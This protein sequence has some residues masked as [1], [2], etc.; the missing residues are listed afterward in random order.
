MTTENAETAE[1]P[2]GWMPGV[3]ESKWYP[4]WESRGYFKPEVD[5]TKPSFSIV[6]PPPNI[7]GSLHLGHALTATIQDILIRWKRMSGFNVL[8]V[9]GTDHAGIATQ[10]VVERELKKTENKTRHDYG[11]EEFVKRIWQWREKYGA[12]IAEQHRVLG[13]SLDWSRERFTMD[14]GVSEAVQ[15][16]FLRLHKEGLIYR[17]RKLI[18][19]DPQLRTAI[20]DLEVDN[21]ERNGSLWSIAYPV[22]GSDEKLVVATTRPE[23]MLG[24]TAVAV[25]S[26]DVRYKHLIGK[27]VMLPFVNR[28][29]PIIADD[30]L[31][32]PK[33]G[34][35][36][37]K[38]TPAHD[39]NDYATGQRHKLPMVNIF[40]DTAHV[41]E[42]GGPYQGLER[43]AARKKILEDLTA[44]GLLIEEKPHKLPLAISQR[45]G[46]PVEPRLSWQ[47]YVKI[48]PLADPAI[49]AVEQG[50]TKFVPESWT[51]TYFSWMRNIHDWCI[52]RQLWWG[53]QIPAWYEQAAD[54]TVD[55]ETAKFVVSKTKPEGN[56]VQD[57]DVLDTWFSSALWPFSTLGWPNT[58]SP[59]LKAFY[60]N[61]VMETGHDIIF[62]WV[63][64]MM[65]MGIKF[66]GDVPFR[67]VYLHAMVRDEKGEKMS[68]TKGNVIDPLDIIQGAEAIKLP[69]SV[70][71][72]YPDG[73]EAMGADALRFTLASLT[74]QGRDIKLSVERIEGY[75]A[76]CNKLFNSSRFALMNMGDFKVDPKIFVK[77]RALSLA[78]RWIL[79]R[80]NV[81]IG[82]VQAALAAYNFGEASSLLYQFLWREFCD[83]Y[84]ELSKGS[85]RGEDEHARDS[86]RAVLVFCLDQVLRA[87]HPFM[88]FI[89]EE[90]W[91]QLPMQRPV[92]SICLASYPTE[93]RRLSDPA[94]EAE[95]KP[96]IDAIDGIRTI[97]GESML[98]PAI[99]VEAHVQSS[100]PSVRETLQRC[101]DYVIQ[102]ARLA[103]LHVSD[104]G[105][106]PPQAAAEIRADMEIYVPL[107]G[108]VDL[109]EERERLKKEIEKAEKEIT[110]MEGRL[111]NPSFVARAPPEV[112]AKD[113]ARVEELRSR[114]SKVN[115]NIKRIAPVE[116]RIAPPAPDGARNLGE[117]LKEELSGLRV[118]ETD[119]QVTEALQKLREGT[120]EGLSSRDHY[121]LGV[122]YMNMGLVD[123][124]VRE[125]NAAK[126][127]EPKKKAPAKKP[128]AKAKAKVVKKKAAPVA[129]KKAAPVKKKPKAK[130]KVA[131]PK[132]KKPVAKKRK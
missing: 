52:S 19:W 78:D 45:T 11:R 100:H 42:N 126:E 132:A 60:P 88:P 38:V 33:F 101:R 92:E 7:T 77:E 25:H 5:S 58:E 118:Q 104:L 55:F 48:Q 117:E 99:R 61:S 87:L 115:D 3:V 66:M 21:E 63:A 22:T 86:T 119:Q 36:V 1:A 109:A 93:D 8:W 2:K 43:F 50:R 122:A 120:K 35:G 59:D 68:K 17:A 103:S 69:P 20:S 112:V 14:E 75:K 94:A 62:F 102:L 54:G 39:H 13:A 51:N 72:K 90:L 98:S 106:K 130:A 46:V 89:T 80:L 70:K 47:W 114:I 12:R 85:L 131:K 125:F 128:A 95:M 110:G 83:W 71:N 111:N 73:L 9:P 49:A 34:T 44:A 127:D 26:E 81:C 76:F 31:V 84:I 30:I 123:D 4:L 108:I 96:V 67:T 40:T 113:R 124:A 105:V 107:A 23:T 10:M 57:P 53:H 65:M 56:W 27:T 6:L 129:K 91:Q 97:R 41:N 32:D 64:R 28:E 79:S 18:N 29:I 121:D 37:V 74:Q 15:E 82:G 16:V 116:V 24:D